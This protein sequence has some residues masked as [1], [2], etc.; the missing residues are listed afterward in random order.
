VFRAVIGASRGKPIVVADARALF[1]GVPGERPKLDEER[2]RRLLDEN[3]ITDA[4]AR[5]L[6]LTALRR[7]AAS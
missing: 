7:A 6:H 2:A 4:S 3:G 1:G 5:T